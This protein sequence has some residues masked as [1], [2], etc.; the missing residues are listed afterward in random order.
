MTLLIT[1]LAAIT[2][3]IVWYFTSPRNLKL[4]VLSWMYWG[5][6]LMWLADAIM[7]YIA[8]GADYFTPAPEDMLNDAFLGFS[9]VTLGLMI[10]L[11]I[12]LWNDPRGVIRNT[13]FTRVE[14]SVE[15]E[16]DKEPL[17][18]H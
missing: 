17:R 1:V 10:W 16:E 9:A 14:T 8:D 18:I 2:A 13:L 3:T 6:S 15:K 5:A 12:L 4:G 7:E 11:G